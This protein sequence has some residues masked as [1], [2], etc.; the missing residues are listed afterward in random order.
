ML[1]WGSMGVPLPGSSEEALRPSSRG[2]YPRLAR[3]FFVVYGQSSEMAHP[4]RK[5]PRILTS[6]DRVR[7]QVFVDLD[8]ADLALDALR[9]QIRHAKA[10]SRR[11][12]RGLQHGDPL[13]EILAAGEN[14]MA[15][16]SFDETLSAF[17]AA[18]HRL[19]RSLILLGQSQGMSVSRLAKLWG[20]SRA[21][22]SRYAREVD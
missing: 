6:V 19:R 11:W 21:L 3:R 22:I 12:R 13:D 8:A 14:P 1:R 2:R 20:V 18:R 7:Q 10:T 5:P 15:R 4:A 9:E 16:Q 17:Q